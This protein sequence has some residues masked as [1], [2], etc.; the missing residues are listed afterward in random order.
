MLN[1]TER[2]NNVIHN[3]Y[4]EAVRDYDKFKITTSFSQQDKAIY[5]RMRIGLYFNQYVGIFLEH[6]K[7]YKEV[8]K[9]VLGYFKGFIEDYRRR[10][11]D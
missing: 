5:I 3:A 7:T 6:Y 1:N 11:S 10:F 9:D 8:Y 4:E 2:F